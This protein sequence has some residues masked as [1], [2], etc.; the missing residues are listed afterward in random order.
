[1]IKLA[2]CVVH[3]IR[4]KGRGEVNIPWRKERLKE[5][6]LRGRRTEAPK[7]GAPS[8]EFLIAIEGTFLGDCGLSMDANLFY[9]GKIV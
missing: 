7:V 2:R 9:I 8:R 1:M 5:Q 6:G 3:A 4:R